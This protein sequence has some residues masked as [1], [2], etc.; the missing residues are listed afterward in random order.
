MARGGRHEGTKQVTPAVFWAKG[1]PVFLH[2]SEPSRTR[3][4]T[5]PGA[6][7]ESGQ[8]PYWILSLVSQA[9]R[10]LCTKRHF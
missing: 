5:G 9:P 3:A 7:W 10:I 2:P 4:E 1:L 8:E 6:A